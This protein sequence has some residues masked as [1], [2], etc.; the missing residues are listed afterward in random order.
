MDLACYVD[1][2]SSRQFCVDAMDGQLARG[3][4]VTWYASALF[5]TGWFVLD[6]TW[7]IKRYFFSTKPLGRLLGVAS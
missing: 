1:L 3:S 7:S 4:L 6:L 5:T 2:C